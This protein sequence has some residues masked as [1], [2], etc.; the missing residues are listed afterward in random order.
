MPE[1][2]QPGVMK[3]EPEKEEEAQ[4]KNEDERQ[5]GST[6]GQSVDGK[7]HDAAQPHPGQ[8][9]ALLAKTMHLVQDLAYHR[10]AML[11]LVAQGNG[12][13]TVAIHHTRPMVKGNRCE[14]LDMI[15]ESRG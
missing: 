13:V 5:R 8:K 3:L 10:S 9:G 15:D 12:Q 6:A 14:H 2:R 1:C 11:P 7:S 4:R